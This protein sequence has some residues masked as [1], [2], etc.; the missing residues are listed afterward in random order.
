MNQSPLIATADGG[1][2]AWSADAVLP[3]GAG[4]IYDQ[5]GN[6]TGTTTV[7][8]YGWTGKAY[9]VRSSGLTVDEVLANPLLAATSFWAYQGGNSSGNR[10]AARPLPDSVKANTDQVQSGLLGSV[11]REIDYY[12]FQGNSQYDPTKA[13]VITERLYHLSGLWPPT[14]CNA[15]GYDPNNPNETF[16]SSSDKHFDD[17]ITTVLCWQ[18]VESSDSQ[19]PSFDR[20]GAVFLPRKKERVA[21]KKP[22]QIEAQRAVKRLEEMAAEGNPPYS[23]CCRWPRPWAG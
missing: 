1:V 20:L 19:A 5:S 10:A 17:L 23:W 21:M 13:I 7:P 16:C 11:T 2:I 14:G 15:P 6:V 22:Y 4:T 3:G 12:P 9:E 8:T 18:I